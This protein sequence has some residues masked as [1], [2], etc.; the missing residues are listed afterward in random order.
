MHVCV[1]YNTAHELHAI[2][3]SMPDSAITM[4]F[5]ASDVTRAIARP[6]A[7]ARASA[8]WR[9]RAFPLACGPRRGTDLRPA[10]CPRAI[11]MRANPRRAR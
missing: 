2:Y 9:P 3:G 10:P 7:L 5:A 8:R 1:T 6:I 11:A 4:C